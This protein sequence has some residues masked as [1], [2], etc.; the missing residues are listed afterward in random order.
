M[1]SNR[2]FP[3]LGLKSIAGMLAISAA[4]CSSGCSTMSDFCT[5]T[6]T[7]QAALGGYNIFAI[8]CVANDV[9]Y[10]G[11]N[12]ISLAGSSSSGGESQ[13][14]TFR[15]SK[16]VYDDMSNSGDVM[17]FILDS[18]DRYK[19][20]DYGEATIEQKQHTVGRY[21]SDKLGKSI[22]IV[23]AQKMFL[24][25]FEK[26]YVPVQTPAPIAAPAPV[27]AKAS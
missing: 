15:S 3:F 27:Q 16:A 2:I 24:V 11:G 25:M 6:A 21:V 10:I 22:V 7:T 1:R 4:V 13:Y 8:P 19:A 17:Q 5:G 18:Q 26:E 12:M 23:D 14:K 9:A 20:L